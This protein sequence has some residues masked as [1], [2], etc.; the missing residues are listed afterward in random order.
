MVALYF[1]YV[2]LRARLSKKSGTKS[3]AT[4][5]LLK[6][7]IGEHLRPGR[8]HVLLA[9]CGHNEKAYENPKSKKGLFTEALLG[10]LSTQPI[11]ELT[12]KKIFE[13]FP[14]LSS[15]RTRWVIEVTLS[16]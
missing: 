6:Q 5:S 10:I 8:S 11:S 12:Y 7:L 2:R 14:K 1:C 16:Q 15:L 3:K 4:F 13:D 9:A